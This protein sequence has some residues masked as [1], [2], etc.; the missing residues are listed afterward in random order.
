MTQ[1][2]HAVETG[3]RLVDQAWFTELNNDAVGLFEAQLRSLVDQPEAARMLLSTPVEDGKLTPGLVAVCNDRVLVL[4]GKGLLGRKRMNET[5]HYGS[6]GATYQ[7]GRIRGIPNDA[8]IAT[9]GQR[10]VVFPSRETA[11]SLCELINQ[12]PQGPG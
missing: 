2:Q 11:E 10:R 1:F 9:L 8:V 3:N 4:W 7:V 6:G 12:P 5:H